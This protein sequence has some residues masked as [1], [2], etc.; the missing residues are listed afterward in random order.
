MSRLLTQNGIGEHQE[1]LHA[2]CRLAYA[3]AGVKGRAGREPQS[4]GAS[5]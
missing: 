3:A 1:G 4:L 5:V 2:L